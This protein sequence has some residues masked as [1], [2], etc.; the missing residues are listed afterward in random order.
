MP[1]VVTYPYAFGA[2]SPIIFTRA[3]TATYFDSTGTLTTAAINSPRLDYNP[4]TLAAQGLLV[5][6]QRVNSLRNNT[7]VG[8]VAGTPGTAPTNWVIQINTTT[9][10]TTQVVGTGTESGITY[11]DLRVSGTASGAGALDVFFENASA[12]AALTGQTWTGSVY[13]KLQGGSLTGISSP[14]FRLYEYTSGVVYVIGQVGVIATPT[15]AGLATQRTSATLTTNGGATVAAIRPLINYVIANGAAIDI[16]LRVGLPQLELGAFATS[17]IPTSTVAVTRA[18]D[19]ANITNLSPWY[20]EAAYTFFGQALSANVSTANQVVASF[21][22]GDFN[23]RNQ[24]VR[25][26]FGPGNT[27][28]AAGMTLAGVTIGTTMQGVDWPSNTVVKAAE[29]YTA[30][31]QIF[32]SNGI[33]A[34]NSPQTGTFITATQLTIGARVDGALQFNGWIQRVT[35]YPSVLSTTQ[36]QSITA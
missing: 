15:T 13:T 24:I 5:E 11:I 2:N 6:E 20:N 16:T 32:A 30:G 14:T 27:K 1:T 28:A 33:L 4:S 17:V 18:A 34:T 23:N 25:A 19:F 10:L 7:M 29:S 36:L 12:V 8:A 35:V 3:S 22:N 9:G 31:Q 21:S 26:Y